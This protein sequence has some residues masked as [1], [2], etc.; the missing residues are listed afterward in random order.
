[1][2]T[3]G[4]E[5]NP[6]KFNGLAASARSLEWTG[7]DTRRPVYEG[8]IDMPMTGAFLNHFTTL[9]VTHSL[10]TPCSYECKDFVGPSKAAQIG[11]FVERAFE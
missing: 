7:A 4:S 8:H 11:L 1:M 3:S 5:E 10:L 6:L 2:R 9:N